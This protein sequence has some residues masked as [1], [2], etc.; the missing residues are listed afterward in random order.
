MELKIAL[1]PPSIQYIFCIY[2]RGRIVDGKVGQ[3]AAKKHLIRV[4]SMIAI[5]ELFQ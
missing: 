1:G 4:I 2:D 3:L 5:L